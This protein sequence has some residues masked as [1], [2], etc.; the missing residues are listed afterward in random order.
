MEITWHMHEHGESGRKERNHEN[1][2]H[3]KCTIPRG[4][5]DRKPD[6]KYNRTQ[7]LCKSYQP[8]RCIKHT[9]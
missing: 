1:C 4:I 5:K 8:T 2:I 9:H 6:P 7:I 3:K